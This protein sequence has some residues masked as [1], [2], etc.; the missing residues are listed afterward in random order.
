M[1][2]AF[3]GPTRS[4][5]GQRGEGGPVAGSHC[6]SQT[7]IP[8]MA[9]DIIDQGSVVV[10]RPFVEDGKGVM[11]AAVTKDKRNA[12]DGRFGTGSI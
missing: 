10:R 1:R 5:V 11:Y 2:I 12:G 9:N 6:S 7:C 8:F 3:I 4:G